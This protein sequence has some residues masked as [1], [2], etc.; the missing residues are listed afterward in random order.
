[1]MQLSWALPD[2]TTVGLV[3]LN[4]QGEQR[5]TAEVVTALLRF[6]LLTSGLIACGLL[7][8]NAGFV[9]AW[10]GSGFFGG[11][12]LNV[13]FAVDVIVLTAVHGIVVPV[14]A[15]GKRMTIGVLTAANGLLHV[16]LAFVLGKAW[17]LP[18][19]AI[20]TALSALVTTLPVGLILLTG[21]TT[22]TTAEL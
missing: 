6:H 21:L 20:A 22:V 18:G 16:V 5:R 3:Q 7:A 13:I 10:V 19:V 4:A 14:G 12:I 17:G 15:L 2:S 9:S 8:G 11:P 1:L